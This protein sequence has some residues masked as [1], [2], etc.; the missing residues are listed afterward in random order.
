MRK[1]L[2]VLLLSIVMIGVSSCSSDDGNSNVTYS[3]EQLAGSWE[4]V[5]SKI[6]DVKGKVAGEAPA[7]NPSGCGS[8]ALIFSGD[9]MTYRKY[10][11]RDSNGKCIEIGEKS[12]YVLKGNRIYELDEVGGLDED[13]MM[14]IIS[15]SD[16]TLLLY[17]GY[18]D[19]IIVNGVAFKGAEMKFRKIK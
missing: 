9:T 10:E 5:S 1:I 8:L 4:H 6:Y 14:E 16:S 13:E 15:L 17:K 3:K 18:E 19:P 12:K 7:E 2:S 11:G